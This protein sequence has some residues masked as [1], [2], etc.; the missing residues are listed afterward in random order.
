MVAS[1]IEA[2]EIVI[3]R[4]L[5]APR[6][7]V[8]QAW[9]D[10][11]QVDKWWGPDGFITTTH[12][13]DVRPGGKWHYTM[14]SPDGV[15]FVNWIEYEEIAPPERLVYHLGGDLDA[16]PMKFHVTVTFTDHS[17]KT[18]VVMRSLFET[19]EDRNKV[20]EQYGAIEGGEQHLA[21]LAEHLS[22]VKS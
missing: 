15:D 5:N 18:E 3:S 16:V 11:E 13:M 19:V 2:R 1:N 7:L 12:E 6:E 20:V 14:H 21:R 17:G 22:G 4:V 8:F 9:T 10:P